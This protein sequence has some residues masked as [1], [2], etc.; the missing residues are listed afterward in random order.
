LPDD[1][2]Q[3]GAEDARLDVWLDRARF[4]RTRTL[5]VEAIER[6]GVRLDRSGQVRK[7]Q[8]P[9]ATVR[10]GDVL[11]LKRGRELLTVEVLALG[12]R[13]GPASEAQRLYRD[14]SGGFDTPQAGG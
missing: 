2:A 7:V 9:G 1:D 12:E 5:A 14:V 6:Y 10:V 8:K 4:Y 3:G 11:T 13:R